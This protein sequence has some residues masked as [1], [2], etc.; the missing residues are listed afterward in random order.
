MIFPFQTAVSSP[1]SVFAAAKI[2]KKPHFSINKT[3]DNLFK[4]I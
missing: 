2:A 3:F 4:N 1:W